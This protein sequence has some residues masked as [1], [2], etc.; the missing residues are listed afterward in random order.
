V[1]QPPRQEDPDR[2]DERRLLLR[3]LGPFEIWIDGCA[4]PLKRPQAQRLLALLAINANQPV[5]RTTIINVVWDGQIPEVQ[6]ENKQIQ[7][8]IKSI[9][10]ALECGG[11]PR[12]AIKGLGAGRYKLRSPPLATDLSQFNDKVAEAE[13]LLT[14]GSLAHAS[15][16][17]SEALALWAGP[18][19]DGLPGRFAE[20]ESAR[21]E[22]K[23]LNALQLRIDID[24]WRGRYRQQVA[25]L[26]SL[27]RSRPENDSLRVQLMLALH[28][29]GRSSEAIDAYHDGLEILAEDRGTKPGDA[30]RMAQRAILA[31][32]PAKD[33]LAALMPLAG[34]RPARPAQPRRGPA[35]CLPAAVADFT[36]RVR[37]LDEL[38]QVLAES[39][40]ASVM[41]I[42][43]LSGTG[44]V[45]KTALA[46]SWGHRVSDRFPDGVLYV[47]L[48]GYGPD[49]AMEPLEALGLL[50]HQLQP[51]E[52][53]PP[54]ADTRAQI[55]RSLLAGKQA[56]V[57]LDNATGAEQVR[58]LLPGSS[59]CM[60]LITSRSDLSGLVARNGARRL[61]LGLLPPEE[62]LALLRR[63]IGNERVDTE[64]AAAA[65]VAQLCCRLPLALR[66]A[67][68]RALARPALRLAEL[69]S[70]LAAE[71]DRLELLATP[72]GDPAT[73]TRIVFSWSYRRLTSQ[74]QRGFR[75]LG[76]ACGT[77]IGIPA[78]AALCDVPS[79]QMCRIL[80]E[81]ASEHLI[82]EHRPG[83]YRCHDLLRAYAAK[84]AQ[85]EETD[86]Q[87]NEAVTR[88][89]T[90]YVTGAD[91]ADRVLLPR[92]L[93][94]PREAAGQSPA[95]VLSFSDHAEALAWCENEWDNLLAA[96]RQASTTGRHAVAWK[97]PAA[98]WGFFYL[99]KPWAAWISSYETGLA[100]ARQ[101]HDAFGEA[102][103][104]YGL[105]TARWSLGQ[106]PAAIGYYEKSLAVWRAISHKWGEAMT[107]NN[108]AAA[109]GDLRQ[110]QTA[111][112]V[113][114]QALRIRQQIGDERGQAQTMINI[115]G[116]YTDIGD[117]PQAFTHLQEAL[118][119]SRQIGYPYGIAVTTHNLGTV[120]AALGQHAAAIKHLRTARDLRRELG[121]KQG[122]AETLDHLGQVQHQTGAISEARASWL[123]ALEKFEALDDP[124]AA[125]VRARL[126]QTRRAT[127]RDTPDQLGLSGLPAE[128]TAD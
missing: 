58:P 108:M 91:T 107:L 112:G 62:A 81:L 70:E 104:L 13:D 4:I 92:T 82:E 24:L 55:Y 53:L 89:L 64:L 10:D 69:A 29:A 114:S 41:V 18:A 99:R 27:V 98:L 36:G 122:Q 119:F 51:P 33:I 61:D 106:L 121:D 20:S 38:D 17:L 105:G 54:E 30:L 93:H 96:I 2:A 9:R 56:L 126:E 83:R 31:G 47:D 44:G 79:G 19:L 118:Q 117:Y 111:L 120:L 11:V 49:P 52:P 40:P 42:S 90:W 87:R 32:Q 102:W 8:H 123:Q 22:E 34:K 109:H 66:I 71:Q 78:A 43:A 80:N 16:A 57:V 48:R 125:E 127:G 97:L 86:Q 84:C 25:E 100:S 14:A 50:I 21:L 23:K 59:R 37:E 63:I 65:E 46:V 73:A 94:I 103:M 67:A 75:L 95:P 68:E 7:V 74:A 113:F 76:V 88:L 101:I 35:C 110:F 6:D 116:C 77:D 3:M 15:H 124:Q 128:P 115:G 5:S 45:G 28:G 85:A 60:A 26:T 1:A 39:Q 12:D 72:D